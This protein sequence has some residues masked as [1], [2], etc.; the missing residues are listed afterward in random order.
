M[1]HETVVVNATGYNKEAAPIKG[2]LFLI[3]CQL[4]LFPQQID[5]TLHEFRQ[6]FSFQHV[7]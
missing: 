1:T 5:T 6:R 7:L 2:S 4:C 3:L